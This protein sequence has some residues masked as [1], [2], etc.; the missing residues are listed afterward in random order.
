M[1]STTGLNQLLKDLSKRHSHF[2][3]NLSRLSEVDDDETCAYEKKYQVWNSIFDMK[4][5]LRAKHL[6]D[7]RKL[8]FGC[9]MSTDGVSVAA[10][11]QKRNSKDVCDDINITGEIKHRNDQT[12]IHQAVKNLAALEKD[13]SGV[14]HSERTIIGLDPGKKS[15]ATWVYHN[16]QHQQKHQKW[17]GDN[18]EHT[19]PE[20]RYKSDSL[21]GGEWR[22][23]SGQEQYTAKMNK[24]MTSFCPGW[25]NLSSTKTTDS[26]KL[27]N[28]YREQI[29]MWDQLETAFFKDTWYQKQRMRKFCRHQMAMED[30]V[31]RICGTRKKEE[32]KKV[33]VAYGDGDHKGTLRGTAPMMSTKLFRKV[34]QSCCVVVVNEFRTSK[35]C[36]C[37]HKD[38]KQF[39]KQF[40]M[41]RCINSD[42]IRLVWDRDVN[43]SINILNL[44]L[45][46]CYSAKEDGTGQRLEAFTR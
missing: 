25:R 3:T 19:M 14:F 39:H 22:F 43:A 46:L 11:I 36:S 9:F 29:G 37:C 24:R 2:K 40:R 4:R 33:I 28:S 23:V 45:E 44:F 13:E 7:H 20:E 12:L 18:G 38:M 34:S 31:A 16:P 41:K 27:L 15:A 35:L 5:V 32:Q 6:K 10:T 1:I 26:S 21:G 42:C 8:R 17:K 30:V